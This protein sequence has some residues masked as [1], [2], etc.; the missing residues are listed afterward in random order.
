[1]AVPLRRCD[2]QLLAD[3]LRRADVEAA[4]RLGCH[5]HARVAREL[6]C[7]DN[8]LDIPAGEVLDQGVLGRR[9]DVKFVDQLV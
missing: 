4:G 7:Q 1:M 6:A 2:Q 9:L 5:D 3:I 8:L